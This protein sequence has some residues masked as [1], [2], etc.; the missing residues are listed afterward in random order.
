MKLFGVAIACFW[1]AAFASATNDV[2]SDGYYMIGLTQDKQSF[3]VGIRSTFYKL[4]NV[5]GQGL[6]V[7][8]AGFLENEFGDNAKAWS[9]TMIVTGLLMLGLT[10]ANFFVCPKYESSD[11]IELQKPQ[12]FFEVF[13]TFFNKKG[14]GL[15]RSV[16]SVPRSRG[17]KL[18]PSNFGIFRVMPSNSTMVGMMSEVDA[19]KFVSSGSVT[20]PGQTISPGTR[21]PPSQTSPLQPRR[22]V[23]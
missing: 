12:G 3:F 17:S 16:M 20:F 19:R 13:R 1:M 6:L 18:T 21:M 9:Y 5:T 14:M 22:P 7:I 11:A 8:L 10:V 15:A 2:A 23:I 4:A